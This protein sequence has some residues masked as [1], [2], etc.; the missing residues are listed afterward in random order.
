MICLKKDYRYI[1]AFVGEFLASKFVFLILLETNLFYIDICASEVCKTPFKTGF[2]VHSNYLNVC[3][4]IELQIDI[5]YRKI[6][7][8]CEFSRFL[9]YKYK[10]SSVLFRKKN[11]CLNIH[12]SIELIDIF[13]QS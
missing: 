2:S 3:G 8:K 12:Y 9:I 1:Q 7:F 4:Q 5:V 10:L 11:R 6:G 13:S